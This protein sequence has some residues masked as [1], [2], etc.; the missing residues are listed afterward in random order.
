MGNIFSAH[1][2]LGN[3]VLRPA[4][5]AYSPAPVVGAAFHADASDPP[6]LVEW[7][8]PC[9][10]MQP[11]E[12]G[13]AEDRATGRGRAAARTW[14]FARCNET[15]HAVTFILRYVRRPKSR[16]TLTPIEAIAIKPKKS[17][18]RENS[19]RGL[20]ATRWSRARLFYPTPLP[21][22]LADRVRMPAPNASGAHH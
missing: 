18:P 20:G 22:R 17:T 10:L 19:P 14:A 7:P 4:N 5:V 6:G 13:I 11:M 9:T 3:A 8:A 15:V 21:C 1:L 12:A 16:H 2:A